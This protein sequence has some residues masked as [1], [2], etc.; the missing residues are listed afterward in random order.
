[1]KSGTPVTVVFKK[2]LITIEMPGR[3]LGSASV[4]DPVSVMVS[5]SQK[6]FS[7]QLMDGKAVQVDLP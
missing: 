2:G 6:T 5:E 4:G 1:V 3:T 7:G